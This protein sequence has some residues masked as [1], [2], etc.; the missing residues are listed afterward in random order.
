MGKQNI[1]QAYSNDEALLFKSTFV[2]LVDELS[3][4]GTNGGKATKVGLENSI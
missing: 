3:L 2:L 1:Q 4:R